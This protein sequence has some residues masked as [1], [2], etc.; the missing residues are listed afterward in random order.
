V[1]GGGKDDFGGEEDVFSYTLAAI[2]KRW[3][4]MCYQL[5]IRISH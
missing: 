5:S 4:E 1:Q 2:E 3:K